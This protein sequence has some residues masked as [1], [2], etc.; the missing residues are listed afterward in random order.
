MNWVTRWVFS[1][2]HK[3]IGTLY[4]IFALIA[5]LIGTVFSLLIRMELSLPGTA[6]LSGDYQMYNVIVT[7]HAFI[8]IFFMVMPALIGGF[9]N[10]M[11]P[12][13]I[14]APDMA[15]PRLNNISF[16]LLPPSF[17]LL[18][19]SSLVEGGAG[20]GW[21]VTQIVIDKQ[22]KNFTRCEKLPLQDKTT[23]GI[24]LITF[25]WTPYVKMFFTWGQFAWLKKNWPSETEKEISRWETISHKCGGSDFNK[26][27]FFQWLVGFTD[28]DGS[29]NV[30]TNIINKKIIFTFKISQKNTNL[31]VL[32][33]IKKNLG[34]GS[35]VEDKDNMAHFLVRDI[36][37]LT[38]IIIPIFDRNPLLTSKEFS[39]K[40]FKKCL[41]IVKDNSLNIIEKITLIEKENSYKCPDTFIPS[42]WINLEIPFVNS[43]IT[44]DWIIGFV[45]AEGSFYITKKETTRL[46]HGFGITQKRDK[47]VLEAIKTQIGITSTIKFNKKGFYSMDVYDTY[48]LKLIKDYFFKTMKGIKSLDYRIWARSFRD[49]GKY[50][51]MLQTQTLLRNIRNFRS[52][53]DQIKSD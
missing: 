34:V 38:N 29:F 50:Q 6:F 32:Y 17:T 10:W 42:K 4:L 11:V 41:T 48:S 37:S 2:N 20:T 7:A 45:E 8:M 21:T 47:I 9:G 25:D 49:K 13:L 30:Y 26:F 39:Y 18:L 16:W 44:K 24:K 23:H 53:E 52:L 19:A 31:R 28:G 12:L 35:V 3:D 1:T 33:F 22:F 36:E 5:G 46:V 51:N 40:K 27:N 14:G 15:F 43:P